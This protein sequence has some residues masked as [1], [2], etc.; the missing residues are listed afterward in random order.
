MRRIRPPKKPSKSIPCGA[1][2]A[3]DDPC[4]ISCSSS[5][6]ISS[7][8]PPSSAR[9]DDDA[10]APPPGCSQPR[11][12]LDL[13][14]TDRTT[15]RVSRVSSLSSFALAM[16]LR[17]APRA[18]T[19]LH[20]AALACSLRDCSGG[21]STS[22]GLLLLE[23]PGGDGRTSRFQPSKYKASSRALT[24]HLKSSFFGG[25]ITIWALNRGLCAGAAGAVVLKPTRLLGQRERVGGEPEGEL[26]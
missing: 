14:I 18:A 22:F 12:A 20:M 8:E 26:V 7:S 15:P 16:R 13:A 5:Q 2:G 6:T 9:A 11:P 23:D 3:S 24:P 1:S 19:R 21:M 17:L 25:G 10:P 4:D